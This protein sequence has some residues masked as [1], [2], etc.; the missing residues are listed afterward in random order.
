MFELGEDL[1]DRIEV[2][3]VW[4]QEQEPGSRSTDGLAHGRPFVA[5]QIVH[6]DDVA[7]QERWHEQLLDI[8]G[9]AGLLEKLWRLK[10]GFDSLRPVVSGGSDGRTAWIFRSFGPVRGAER[11]G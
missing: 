3:A 4:R 7:G 8:V 2:R 1:F 10:R 9:K 6:D 11:G 5:G